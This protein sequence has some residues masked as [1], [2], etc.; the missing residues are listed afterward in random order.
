M[1]HVEFVTTP[2]DGSCGVGEYAGDLLAHVRAD[3]V[4]VSRTYLDRDRNDSASYFA[5]LA[6]DVA[7]SDGDVVHVQHEYGLFRGSPLNLPGF[8]TFVLYGLL[9]P[10]C[11]L[12]GTRLVT[13]MH[14]VYAL[15]REE[16]SLRAIAYL[17]VLHRFVLLVSDAVVL[18]SENAYDRLAVLD[19]HGRCTFVP[20]GVEPHERR[21]DRDE[22]REQFGYD[23]DDT[24]IS[25]P[26]YVDRRKGHDTF[27]DLADVLPEYEFL[28]AGGAPT[29]SVEAYRRELEKQ[30][31]ANVQ[32][33][34]VLDDRAFEAAFEAADV[35]VLP[36]TEINQSGVLNRCVAHRVPVVASSLPY[37]ER[38]AEAGVVRT[39]DGTIEA[40]RRHVTD[41][42]GDGDARWELAAAMAEYE[43]ANSFDRVAADHV[44]L[45]RNLAR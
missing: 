36:Y 15:D 11:T 31:G 23:P 24:V 8:Y 20:H 14:S 30:A 19:G 37:F 16:R 12:T 33:T 27:L 26:G 25:L 13:T 34:G 21:V 7:R 4:T 32:F 29:E 10:Y 35:V 3:D 17:Y 28:V 1:D 40:F 44:E 18:L 45:Y 9:L 6:L 39:C 22:A 5:A 38:L 43:A 2:D 42:V 41:L